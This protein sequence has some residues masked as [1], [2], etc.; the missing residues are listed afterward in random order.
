MA[1]FDGLRT[2]LTCITLVRQDRFL[3]FL[4][5]EAERYPTFRRHLG[6]HVRELVT[7]G[8]AVR[9]ARYQ[10]QDGWREV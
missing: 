10:A 2:R 1:S 8:E 7:E 9:G 5:A 3:D 4:A 6:A